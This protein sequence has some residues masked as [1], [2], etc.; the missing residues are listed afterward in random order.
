[1]TSTLTPGGDSTQG[2]VPLRSHQR[3][4]TQMIPGFPTFYYPGIV[5][6]KTRKYYQDPVTYNKKGNLRER[7]VAQFSQNHYRGTGK[8]AE[9]LQKTENLSPLAKSDLTKHLFGLW[10]EKPKNAGVR[11]SQKM[12]R[13]VDMDNESAQRLI[14]AEQMRERLRLKLLKAH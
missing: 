10:K 7:K 14:R 6:P 3:T 9:T 13:S 1:M 4:T 5:N 8:F 2:T 12:Q 11:M